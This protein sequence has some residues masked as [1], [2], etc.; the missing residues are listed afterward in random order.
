MMAG[1]AHLAHGGPPEIDGQQ[2]EGDRRIGLGQVPVLQTGLEGVDEPILLLRQPPRTAAAA[3]AAAVAAAAVAGGGGAAPLQRLEFPHALADL[4]AN[5]TEEHLGRSVVLGGQ[6]AHDRGQVAVVE[7]EGP[8]RV[9]EQ[10]RVEVHGHARELRG[11]RVQDQDLPPE[12]SPDLPV[13]HGKPLEAG[14][15]VEAHGAADAA[16]D[17]GEQPVRVWLIQMPGGQ[18]AGEGARGRGAPIMACVSFSIVPNTDTVLWSLPC[19]VV[20]IVMAVRHSRGGKKGE[21]GGTD[22]RDR[23]SRPAG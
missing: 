3:A 6:L 9:G 17:A 18:L 2:M 5:L 16:G 19:D 22:S 14:F 1:Q 8:F 15:A 7:I 23:G 4:E 11:A 13:E 21:E 12:P 10:I 20:W